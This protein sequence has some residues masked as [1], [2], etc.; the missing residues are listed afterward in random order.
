MSREAFTALCDE[1]VDTALRL[2]P[3]WAS[4]LGVHDHDGEL[5]DPSLGAV[6]RR[7]D[8]L[9]EVERRL[10]AEVDES[11]LSPAERVD[12]RLLRSFV[13]GGLLLWERQREAERSPFYYPDSCLFGLFVLFAREFAPLAERKKPLLERLSRVRGYLREA[14]RTVTSSPRLFAEIADEVAEA[15]GAFVDEIRGVL[16]GAF[17][18]ERAAIDA[19][20]DDAKLGFAEY[21]SWL[22][23]SVLPS[24]GEEFAVGRE[25][26]DARLAE[27]H[28]L[29]YDADS[30]EALGWRAL[31]DTQSEMTRLAERLAPGKSWHDLVEVGK[32]RTP[33]ADRLLDVY[34]EETDRVRAF[35]VEKRLAPIPDGEELSVIE[36][37]AY[38]RSRI[39]YAA[40]LFPG[41]FDAVQRGFFFVT[42][43]DRTGTPKEQREQL[44]GHNIYGVPLT[45]LHE[46]YPGHHLQLCWANRSRS[47][48]RK[49]ADSAVLAEGWALYCEELM[50]E[51]GYYG[52]PLVRLFQLKDQ[53][54]R[55]AR[56]VVDCKLQ[57]GAMSFD[58]A[59]EFLVRE[60]MLERTNAVA[61]VKRYT[62]SPTQPMSY[63][64]GKMVLLTLREEMKA[65]LGPRFD[66]HDFHGAVLAAGTLPVTLVCDE[67]RARAGEP[68]EATPPA[69]R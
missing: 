20:C 12:A 38:D 40:Y 19:A 56:V 64:T 57:T 30:L 47:R 16:A 62:T 34:R 5:G 27:E 22:A 51:Q 2:D 6:R 4:I 39:P 18:D 53:A 23:E 54:W 3:V 36:T 48:L 15:A 26:F 32:K 35:I 65:R 45:A 44:E 67:V 69:A 13:R 41:P 10:D 14:Q 28:L 8:W 9:R 52:D 43:I 46:A 7:C 33:D 17:P 58:E 50:H 55:A 24:A 68:A 11:A 29:P 25:I 1:Y 37:P 66:L 31:R 59:V 21:R 42:P 61:E 49:L 60:A 63:L